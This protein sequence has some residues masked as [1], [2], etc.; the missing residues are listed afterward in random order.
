MAIYKPFS[1]PDLIQCL[2][3]HQYVNVRILRVLILVSVFFDRCC[4]C[5]WAGCSCDVE[6]CLLLVTVLFTLRLFV[7][8]ATVRLRYD[9]SFTLRRIIDITVLLSFAVAIGG[10]EPLLLTVIVECRVYFCCLCGYAAV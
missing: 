2:L 8:V 1:Y 7:Y 3:S 4:V 5:A 6:G 9:C 10:P